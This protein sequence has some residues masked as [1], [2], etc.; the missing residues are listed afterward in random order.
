MEV[1]ETFTTH[2]NFDQL[3]FEQ[4]TPPVTAHPNGR[5]HLSI[6]SP[7]ST[8]MHSISVEGGNT[9]IHTLDSELNNFYICLP[10]V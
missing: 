2:R 1:G 9:D 6:S 7:F 4:D 8:R 5:S 3:E 10:E